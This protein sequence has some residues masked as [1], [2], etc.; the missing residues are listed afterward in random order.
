MFK[1]SV[2]HPAPGVESQALSKKCTWL[3]TLVLIG[4]GVLTSFFLLPGC[5]SDNNPIGS[6]SGKK[7]TTAKST[8]AKKPQAAIE[9]LADKQVIVPGEREKVRPKNDSQRLEA[10]PGLTQAELDA[11]IA[12]KRA[13]RDPNREV[14]PGLTQAELDAKI[15]AH[16]AN[17]DDPNREVLPGVTQAQVDAKIAAQRA[18]RD[19][20]REVLPGLT[21]AQMDAKIAAHRAQGDRLTQ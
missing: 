9:I 3:R 6:N 21:Q 2:S 5:G 1:V 12:E 10:L 17:R 19:P 20:N 4:L 18:K 8:V 11:K 13:N 7:A 16:R 14:L 15:A